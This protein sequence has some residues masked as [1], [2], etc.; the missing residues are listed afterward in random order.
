MAQQNQG[1]RKLPS[2]HPDVRLLGSIDEA[3]VQRFLDQSGAAQ[4]DKPLVL[5]LSTMGGDAE[6]AR[7]LAEE[8]VLL[9]QA[10]EVFFLGK[11]YVYSAGITVMGAVPSTHRFLTPDTILLVHE[12]RMERTVQM[13][14][15]LRSAIAVAR[16]LLAELEI[17]QV[18]ERRGF[19][20]LAAGSKLSAD[21]LLQ[22][23]LDKDW[24]LTAEEALELELIGGIVGNGAV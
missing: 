5:E 15:A 2:L 10:R 23:V 24:Y 9:R 3:M 17:G 21:E 6:S 7:R 12:R 1:K 19:E 16:D 20:Q 22:R 13:T 11:T 14:G 4:G 18:L 8:I